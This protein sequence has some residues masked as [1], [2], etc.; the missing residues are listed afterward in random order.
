MAPGSAYLHLYYALASV[1]TISV[2]LCIAVVDN[3][4]HFLPASSCRWAVWSSLDPVRAP[5]LPL[6][7]PR[8]S[9]HVSPLKTRAPGIG[10]GDGGGSIDEGGG[11][12]SSSISILLSPRRARLGSAIKGLLDAKCWKSFT[13]FYEDS[14]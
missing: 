11:G 7:M 13:V 6:W 14:L 2:L 4:M 8:A 3:T 9:G 1:P 10:I 5:V 12:D